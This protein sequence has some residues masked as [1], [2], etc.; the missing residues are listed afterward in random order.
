M[1]QKEI[2]NQKFEKIDRR[3]LTEQEK[4][5][6]IEEERRQEEEY[7]KKLEARKLKGKELLDELRKMRPY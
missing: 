2:I 6:E 4:Q 7:K 3:A 5:R 1:H